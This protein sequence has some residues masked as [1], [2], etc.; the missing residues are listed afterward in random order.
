MTTKSTPAQIIEAV[1]AAGFKIIDNHDPKRGLETI[2]AVGV[3][4]A[5]GR[6]EVVALYGRV[7]YFS[8]NSIYLDEEGRP[9]LSTW[10]VGGLIKPYGDVMT[11]VEDYNEGQKRNPLCPGH[12]DRV[13]LREA[14]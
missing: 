1:K 11:G 12:I 4:K 14:V 13:E 7:S 9:H 6:E 3:H 5:G 2:C 10:S 8:V